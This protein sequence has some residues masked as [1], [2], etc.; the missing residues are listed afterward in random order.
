MVRE[1]YRLSDTA[2]PDAATLLSEPPGPAVAG[3]VIS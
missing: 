3:E 1:P 2:T